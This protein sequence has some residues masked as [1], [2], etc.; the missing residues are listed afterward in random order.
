M[1]AQLLGDLVVIL[2]VFITGSYKI[3]AVI[4]NKNAPCYFIS[5]G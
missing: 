3:K 4:T 5:R 1:S 2:S